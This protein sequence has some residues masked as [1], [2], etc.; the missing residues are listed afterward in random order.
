MDTT[1]NFPGE[2]L[3]EIIFA[4]SP[5]QEVATSLLE[6]AKITRVFDLQ[7]LVETIDEIRDDH[8]TRQRESNVVPDSEGESEDEEGDG[9]REVPY[10]RTKRGVRLVVVDNV[11]LLYATMVNKSQLQG[12]FPFPHR[13]MRGRGVCADVLGS[14]QARL[15]LW[16]F[17]AVL[18]CW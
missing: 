18:R 9:G 3:K 14:V 15:C 17:S 10:E 5:S 12:M 1:G 2:T 16:R 8:R 7:G 13:W 4:T 11:T 6:R